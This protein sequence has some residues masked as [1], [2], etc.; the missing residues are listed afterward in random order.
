M[1][2][3]VRKLEP[4]EGENLRAILVALDAHV[5]TCE[6]CKY[7]T[8]RESMCDD[9]RALYARWDSWLEGPQ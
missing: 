3:V 4:E 6:V 7:A 2:V 5:N 1:P 8:G 9:G